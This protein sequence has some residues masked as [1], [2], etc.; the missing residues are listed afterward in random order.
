MLLGQ[1]VAMSV[2]TS[3]FISAITLHPRKSPHPRRFPPR[4][5]ILLALT[6]VAIYLVPQTV[7]TERFLNNLLWLH[8]L[9][10]VAVLQPRGEDAAVEGTTVSDTPLYLAILAAS[11]AIHGLNSVRFVQSLSGQLVLAHLYRQVLTNP[12]QTS[13]S[14]DVVWVALALVAWFTSTGSLLEVTGKIALL[15]VV[16]VAAVVRHTGINWGL[17]A[18]VLPIIALSGVGVVFL[19]LSR[20]RSRNA[21]KRRDLLE[22][23]GIM[24]NQVIA[25]TDK[26]PPSAVGHK[27]LVGFFHPYW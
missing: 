3:L 10:V 8:G 26:T 22:S 24:E 17:V 1:L 20:L 27:I 18:S 2:A 9:L 14:L 11:T 5:Y 19:G 6:M 4:H 7:G 13:I 23:M 16:A 12:A 25:G 21:Q 15:S